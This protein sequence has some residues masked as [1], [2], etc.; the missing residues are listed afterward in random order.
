MELQPRSDLGR[1][2]ECD[3]AMD[4]YCGAMD[5]LGPE[6]SELDPCESWYRYPQRPLNQEAAV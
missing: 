2:S 4:R 6:V 5:L 1:D 3:R